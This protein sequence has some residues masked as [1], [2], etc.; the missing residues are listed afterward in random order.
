[1]TLWAGH[2]KVRYRPAKFSGHRP[3][4]GRD[5]VVLL[6]YVIS[7]H[8]MIKKSCDF[9]GDLP[10]NV[11]YHPAKFGGYSHC[12]SGGITILVCHVTLRKDVTS[13]CLISLTGLPNLVVTGI[14][15]MEISIPTSD[16]T[17]DTLVKP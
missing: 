13:T 8:H 16:R 17:M 5:I 14:I 7:K 11:N 3:S 9:T 1:M 10:I 6:F 4:A 12:G 15:E 2:V